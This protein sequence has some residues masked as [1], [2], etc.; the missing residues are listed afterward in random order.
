MVVILTPIVLMVVGIPGNRFFFSPTQNRRICHRHLR[1]G[2][3]LRL[4]GAS[5][6]FGEADVAYAYR[7]MA[8]HDDAAMCAYRLGYVHLEVKKDYEK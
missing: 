1:A 3:V 5:G 6:G 7:A 2:A 4:G 8:S